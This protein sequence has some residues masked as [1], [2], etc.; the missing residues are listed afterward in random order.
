[1]AVDITTLYIGIIVL[2]IVLSVGAYLMVYQSMINAYRDALLALISEY[3]KATMLYAR[4]YAE[5]L[6]IIQQYLNATMS[7]GIVPASIPPPP[8]VNLP[9]IP[10]TVTVGVPTQVSPPITSWPPVPTTTT[11]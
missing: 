11:T 1:M 3:D 2:I 7:N 10:I 4:I 5:Y 6:K 9:N 8:N